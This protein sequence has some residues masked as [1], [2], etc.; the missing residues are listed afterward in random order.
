MI[1]TPLTQKAIGIAYEAHHGQFDKV[2]V[3]YI[4]HPLHLA[5]QMPDEL[6][7]CV[8][9]LHDVVEDSD[10]TLEQLSAMGI[11]DEALQVLQLL[12][13]DPAEPYMQY[14]ERIAANPTAKSVKLADL[15][16]NSD[17]TRLT[18][19]DER[20]QARLD[21]YHQAIAYLHNAK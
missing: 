19:I 6:C 8:A 20:M 14:V 4:H 5:E 7:C 10:I 3:P 15:A 11:P 21:K 17:T 18:V 2:G 12:T 16:H 1:Y 13:H 9:L